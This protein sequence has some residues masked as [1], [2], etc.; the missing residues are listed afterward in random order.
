VFRVRF[1]LRRR[2]DTPGRG[3]QVMRHKAAPALLGLV[4]VLVLG[5]TSA[6]GESAPGDNSTPGGVRNDADPQATSGAADEG[7]SDDASARARELTR[8]MRDNGV[9]DFP[10]PNPDGS[11]PHV[12]FNDARLDLEEL[13]VVY[14]AC[15]AV[16]DADG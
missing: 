16:L 10:D 14:A 9:P 2:E 5:T 11:I 8:C 15:R 6:C 4:L 12:W 3:V 13:Q 1:V 7:D